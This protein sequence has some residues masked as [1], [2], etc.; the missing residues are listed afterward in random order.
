MLTSWQQYG[1][2]YRDR[3][4]DKQVNDLVLLGTQPSSHVKVSLFTRAWLVRYIHVIV[5]RV[6]CVNCVKLP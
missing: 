3:P 1:K 5:R 4:V 2:C 6:N